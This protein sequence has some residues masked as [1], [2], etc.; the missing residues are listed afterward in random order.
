MRL[1]EKDDTRTIARHYLHTMTT[2]R[3]MLMIA[4]EYMEKDML[5]MF[6]RE[7]LFR[8]ITFWQIV[9]ICFALLIEKTGVTL[10]REMSDTSF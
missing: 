7:P 2:D 6:D 4:K 1:K 5:N 10:G 9:T 8:R 3:L